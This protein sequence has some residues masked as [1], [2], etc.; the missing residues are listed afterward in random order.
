MD[1]RCR[2]KERGEEVVDAGLEWN[3]KPNGGKR[4]RERERETTEGGRRKV[5][6]SDGW[7]KKARKG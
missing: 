4:E 1:G 3:P 6:G 7:Q 2:T 5:R